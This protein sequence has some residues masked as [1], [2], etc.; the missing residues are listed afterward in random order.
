MEGLRPQK[1]VTHR[2]VAA[3]WEV[4]EGVERDAP[5]CRPVLARWASSGQTPEMFPVRAV[6][7]FRERGAPEARRALRPAPRLQN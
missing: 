6:L 5:V 1:M 7:A 3:G 4:G 2:V